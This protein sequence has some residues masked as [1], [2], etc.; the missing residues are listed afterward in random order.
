MKLPRPDRAT[1]KETGGFLA[2]VWRRMLNDNC[3]QMAGSLSFTSLLALVPLTTIAFAMFAAFPV[4][5]AQREQIRDFVIDNFIPGAVDNVQSHL[6][7]FVNNAGSLTSIGILFL[8]VTAVLLLV[9]I[10]TALNTIFRVA[11]PRPTINRI[12][13]Y[14]AV[15]TLL[16][17]LV[18]TSF[19]MS[20]YLQTQTRAV[21]A[22]G[23]DLDTFGYLLRGLP[24]LLLVTAFTLVFKIV[25]N[26]PVQWKYA[27]LGGTMAGLAFAALRRGFGTYLVYFPTYE[28][29]YGALATLPI[30]MVWMYMSWLV[31]LAG[32][33]LTA[34]LPEWR[35][36]HQDRE[37][38]RGER[39]ALAVDLLGLLARASR[40]GGPL[41]YET[42]V[43]NSRMS[44][45]SVH[46]VLCELRHAG[47]VAAVGAE[48]AWV[49]ARDLGSATVYDLLQDLGIATPTGEDDAAPLGRTLSA[50]DHAS[51][52][53][54]GRPLSQVVEHRSAEPVLS[55]AQ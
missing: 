11:Q 41:G 27:V 3:P 47:Y 54:L 8:G 16:P 30:L 12:L 9:S 42:I 37:I 10:E 33:S 53:H 48:E 18:G 6:D 44:D 50:A 13:V 46:D 25:P 34:A 55:A 22:I 7:A 4:F 51:R 43:D 24:A 36:R 21:E 45:S 26:R 28:A 40:N 52:E 19:S 29:V 14:W 35:S 38:T 23:G 5:R 1:L 39:I 15:L 17:L 31:V 20:A 2:F 49:L 32:A